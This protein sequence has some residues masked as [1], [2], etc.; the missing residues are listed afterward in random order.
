MAAIPAPICSRLG[1]TRLKLDTIS[2]ARGVILEPISVAAST[3]IART[4]RNWLA[5]E[6]LVRAASP[7]ASLACS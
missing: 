7:I 2:V 3:T 6:S 4:P 5:K 1:N